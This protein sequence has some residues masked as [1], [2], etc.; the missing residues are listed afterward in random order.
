MSTRVHGRVIL[1]DQLKQQEVWF[2]TGSQ[3][4]YGPET[5]QRVADNSAKVAAALDS[6]PQVPCRVIFKPVVKTPDEILGLLTEANTSDACVGLLG[7]YFLTDWLAVDAIIFRRCLHGALLAEK[8]EEIHKINPIQQIRNVR[9]H[10]Y[11]G[12]RFA[13]P[14][15]RGIAVASI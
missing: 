13:V 14:L 3:H 2:V 5:L 11:G 8:H 4:L 1:A 6:S 9:Q 10:S 7:F 12:Y 15:L